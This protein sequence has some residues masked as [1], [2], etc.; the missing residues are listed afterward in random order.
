MPNHGAP[1]DSQIVHL[2]SLIT[3]T[4]GDWLGVDAA[5]G[6][7]NAAFLASD[8]WLIAQRVG[9]STVQTL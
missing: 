4:T 2:Q 1:G 8:I 7:Q 3:L 6:A 9:I 5:G